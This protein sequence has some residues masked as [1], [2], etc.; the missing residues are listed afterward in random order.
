METCSTRSVG[1]NASG[2]TDCNEPA[3]AFMYMA[4]L[5]SFR[6]SF[7]LP[8]YKFL[9][10]HSPVNSMSSCNASSCSNSLAILRTA[11]ED[12]LIVLLF[13]AQI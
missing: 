4:Y 5:S 9:K 12:A 6:D 13:R 7:S 2:R 8:L 11:F 10:S 1:G 3:R